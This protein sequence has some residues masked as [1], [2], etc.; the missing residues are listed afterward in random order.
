MKFLVE[1]NRMVFFSG[2]RKQLDYL[3]TGKYT[4]ESPPYRRDAGYQ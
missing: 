4:P 2:S 1:L 3:S